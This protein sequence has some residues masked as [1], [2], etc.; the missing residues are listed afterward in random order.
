MK[1]KVQEEPLCETAATDGTLLL[2][3]P[4]YIKGL[5]K[6]EIIGLEAHEVM[7]CAMGD[8]WRLD[9]RDPFLWNIAC[10]YVN[11]LILIDAQ[12]TLPKGALVEQSYRNKSKEEVYN[13]LQQQQTDGGKG[14]Q[15]GKGGQQGKGSK[16]ADPGKCGGMFSPT[17]K[18]AAKE[19]A[20]DWKTATAQA[21]QVSQGTLPANLRKMVDECL[22]PPLPWDVLLRDFV[23][24]TARNDY[25]WTRP[26][27]RYM[28]QNIILPSLLS[29]ELVRVVVAA[30]SSGS[31]DHAQNAFGKEISS[32]LAAFNTTIT[33]MYCDAKV[34]NVKEYSTDELPIELE[35]QGGGG[36]S[37]VPVFDYVKE[38]DL[39]PACLVYLTDLYGRF[40]QVEPDYPVLWISVTKDKKAPWGETVFMQL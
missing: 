3:N 5:S 16:Y 34:Y 27:R 13:I 10:D 18:E 26:N 4:E 31:C 15:Q 8:I 7:H 24:R 35:S 2:I 20:V 38:N 1:L 6:Q 33:T 32:V 11:N 28:P 22:D 12:F 39:A 30:D 29:D 17:D 14:S 21:A 25:N 36:T 19:S 40:P 37:F 9:E 23:Q